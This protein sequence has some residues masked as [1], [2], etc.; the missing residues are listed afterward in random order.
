MSVVGKNTSSHTTE[1]QLLSSRKP[2]AGVIRK[3]LWR[4]LVWR[5][6]GIVSTV[7]WYQFLDGV[8]SARP[9]DKIIS[10]CNHW[11]WVS[12][13]RLWA[14]TIQ[15]PRWDTLKY[16]IF[17]ILTER[18]SVGK[19]ETVLIAA[20]V[21]QTKRVIKN[22]GHHRPLHW[23]HGMTQTRPEQ[24]EPGSWLGWAVGRHYRENC[25]LLL[26]SETSEAEE[27]GWLICSNK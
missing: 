4:I 21:R 24:M 1:L 11:H 8:I 3:G 9:G 6:V 20:T 19:T 25:G 27:R 13:G 22:S 23:S 15:T 17:S 5:R 18:K 2:S 7:I 14:K 26:S 10:N 12:D 16:P